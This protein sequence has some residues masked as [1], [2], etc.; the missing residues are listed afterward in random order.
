MNKDHENYMDIEEELKER[1]KD[2]AFNIFLVLMLVGMFIVSLF[3]NIALVSGSSME[4]TL[5]NKD[6]A[7]FEK[8]KFRNLEYNRGDIIIADISRLNYES[9]GDKRIIKRIIGIPGDTINI[10][11]GK[12]YVNGKIINEDYIFEGINTETYEGY[13]NEWKLKKNEYFI[14]GDNRTHDG[15]LDSRVLGKI[16]KD[17]IYGKVLYRFYPVK[18]RMPL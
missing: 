18:N 11:N 9:F 1:K 2:L 10:N 7:I 3:Y 12:V 16:Y 8:P 4:P 13:G 17:E 5:S 15:S 6:A 14:M